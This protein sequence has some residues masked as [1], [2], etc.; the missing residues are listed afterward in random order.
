[1]ASEPQEKSPES[2]RG[3]HVLPVPLSFRGPLLEVQLE[4]GVEG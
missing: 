2:G 4:E 1:M 3:L